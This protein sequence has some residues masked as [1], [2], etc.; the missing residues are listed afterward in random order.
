ML[1]ITRILS[2]SASVNSL[3]AG[4]AI[5]QKSIER[6]RIVFMGVP[7]SSLIFPLATEEGGR[8]R[9]KVTVS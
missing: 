9:R 4:N 6:A 3:R 5:V 8:K 2:R 1:T 7:V